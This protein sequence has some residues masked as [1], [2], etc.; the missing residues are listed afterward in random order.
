MIGPVQEKLTSERVNAMK[1]M[2]A[3][4]PLLE[5]SSALFT[6]LLGSVISKAP[7]KE[8]AKTKNSRK[9]K[10]LNQGLVDS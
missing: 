1:K 10:M 4:P 8:S 5:A 9:N 7:K 2:P 6:Q 3:K